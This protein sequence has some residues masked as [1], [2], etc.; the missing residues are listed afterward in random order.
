MHR[1][2]AFIGAC[3]ISCAMALAQSSAADQP[4]TANPNGSRGHAAT[5]APSTSNTGADAQG[6]AQPNTS[7]TS[8]NGAAG[9]AGSST[10]NGAAGTAGSNPP[11]SDNPMTPPDLSKNRGTFTAPGRTSNVPWFWLALVIIVGVIAI[12]ALFNRNRARGNIDRTD[13]ALR[14]TRDRSEPIRRDD[15]IRRVG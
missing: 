1:I 15:N 8:A 10:P 11:N 4:Q 5:A 12:L 7:S 14:A 2:L 13:P 3:V 9:T 6:Q